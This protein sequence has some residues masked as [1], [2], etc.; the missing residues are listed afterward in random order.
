MIVPR[1][2]NERKMSDANY[3]PILAPW[4]YTQGA[5]ATVLDESHIA[6]CS[7]FEITPI[8]RQTVHNP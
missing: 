2:E 5:S 4:S 6:V 1:L 7:G 8:N 3:K